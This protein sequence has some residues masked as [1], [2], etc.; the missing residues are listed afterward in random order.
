MSIIAEVIIIEPNISEEE[1]EKN[2]KG[3]IEV[4]KNIAIEMLECENNKQIRKND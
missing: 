1:S 4:L 3:V 2:L